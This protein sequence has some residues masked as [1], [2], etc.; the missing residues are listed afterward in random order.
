MSRKPHHPMHTFQT[1]LVYS[2]RYLIHDPGTEHAENAGRLRAIVAALEES[3]LR[4]RL[5]VLSPTPAETSQIIRVHDAAHVERVRKACESAPANLDRDTTVSRDSYDVALLAAGGVL[6]AVDAVMDGRVRN[7]FCAVRP[8]GHHATRDKAMG[9]CL[10]NNVAI[11]AR[12]IQDKHA[13]RRILI[14]DWDAH[15]GNGTQEIFYGDP[16]VL[17]FSA[18]QFP[19]YPGTGSATESGEGPGKG[20][21]INV[22]MSAGSGDAEYL[23]AFSEILTPAAEEFKPE[24]VLISAG[25]DAHENDPLTNLNVTTE[26]FAALTA[27]VKGIADTHCGGRLVSVLEGGYHPENLAAAVV[28]HVAVLMGRTQQ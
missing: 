17:Y 21:T 28:A 2:E 1:A 19:C 11:A 9:F 8:P 26:G 16:E 6:K 18:H 3:G 25:F 13:I 20:F 12:H 23:K 27:L 14:V 24:F 10:F 4:G 22:P 7:A 15:H 5:T